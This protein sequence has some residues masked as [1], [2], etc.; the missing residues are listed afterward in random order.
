MAGTGTQFLLLLPETYLKGYRTLNVTFVLA[1]P[2]G[3]ERDQ[4]GALSTV[5]PERIRIYCC[6]KTHLRMIS[7]G[8][9]ASMHRN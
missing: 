6:F 8:M 2:V 1:F 7:I 4:I 9:P 3:V 5:S